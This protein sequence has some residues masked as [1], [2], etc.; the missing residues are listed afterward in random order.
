[1]G[2]H[3]DRRKKLPRKNKK[4][5]NQWADVDM[6]QKRWILIIN[7]SK[8]EWADILIGE[9]SCREEKQR[10]LNQWADIDIKQKRWILTKNIV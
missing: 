8:N 1:M 2:R 6:K 3:S 4:F 9:K 5:L 7:C 10:A